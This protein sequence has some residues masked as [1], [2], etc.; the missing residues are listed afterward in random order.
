MN[1]HQLKSEKTKSLMKDVAYKLFAEKGY[2]ATSIDDITK[3]AGYTKGAFYA[4][5]NNKEEIFLQIMDERMLLLHQQIQDSITIN[6]ESTNSK[7]LILSIFNY[8]LELTQNEMWTSMYIEFV[9]N[10]SRIPEIQT[11]LTA[12]YQGWKIVIK[13]S[14][15]Y[16]LNAKQINP[17]I[18]TDS[19]A[20]AIVA[21]FDGYNIQHHVDHS[22]EL[23]KQ[24]E[25]IHYLLGI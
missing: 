6:L 18:P 13:N 17:K 8:L 22:V 19:L 1:K 20:T 24:I 12:I 4:H 9:A 3:G 5:F 15:D 7:E 25:I 14:L 10:S 11:K 16:L 23:K 21:I 2:S